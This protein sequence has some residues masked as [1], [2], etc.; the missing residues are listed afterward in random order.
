MNQTDKIDHAL[1]ELQHLQMTNYD[2][3]ERLIGRAV[4]ILNGVTM[5]YADLDEEAQAQVLEDHEDL[6]YDGSDPHEYWEES[7]Y[8]FHANGLKN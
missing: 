8:L 4:D 2:D 3:H 6:E 7:I 1:E 5:E